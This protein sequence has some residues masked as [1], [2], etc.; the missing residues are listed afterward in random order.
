MFCQR[1]RQRDIVHVD[2]NFIEDD[3]SAF[4]LLEGVDLTCVRRL[5]G[6]S[7]I[8]YSTGGPVHRRLGSRCNLAS[9]VTLYSRPGEVSMNKYPDSHETPLGSSPLLV[10]TSLHRE[11]NPPALVCRVH[12][13]YH[14]NNHLPSSPSPCEGFTIHLLEVICLIAECC[15][16]WGKDFGDMRK[17]GRNGKKTKQSFLVLILD[18]PLGNLIVVAC[19]HSFIIPNAS[20]HPPK[21]NKPKG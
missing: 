18:T 19:Q 3:L 21:K 15:M 12:I 14:G 10:S 4:L 17:V 8:H 2:K 1:L 6:M 5:S 9:H 16:C 13:K 20:T 11:V 7:N